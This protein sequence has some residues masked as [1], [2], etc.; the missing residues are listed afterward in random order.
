LFFEDL[1][2]KDDPQIALTFIKG[3]LNAS[4]TEIDDSSSTETEE[5]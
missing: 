4:S 5:N 2:E 1:C 3:L